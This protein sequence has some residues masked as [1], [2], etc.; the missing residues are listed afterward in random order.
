MTNT[1]NDDRD[2]VLADLA[3]ESE[4][5]DG[6]EDRLIARLREAGFFHPRKGRLLVAAAAAVLLFVAGALTG[7]G[8]AWRQSFE[9][10]LARGEVDAS[11]VSA[12]LKRAGIEPLRAVE[13]RSE[14]AIRTAGVLWF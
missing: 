12:V 13:P 5:I 14:D 2:C 11:E 4:L 9:A 7:G 8:L 3:R 10:R 6:E 1:D